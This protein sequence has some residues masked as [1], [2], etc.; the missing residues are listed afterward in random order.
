MLGLLKKFFFS[1]LSV[2]YLLHFI[3]KYTVS[4]NL[5]AWSFSLSKYAIFAWWNLREMIMLCIHWKWSLVLLF[6]WSFNFHLVEQ[7]CMTFWNFVHFEN[8]A[9]PKNTSFQLHDHCIDW[10]SSSTSIYLKC[11]NTNYTGDVWIWKLHLGL[12]YVAHQS[13]RLIHFLFLFSL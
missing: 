3:Q 11:P 2:I 4:F 13:Q 6:I 10:L 9:P 1:I 12:I 7:T 5:Q 8:S